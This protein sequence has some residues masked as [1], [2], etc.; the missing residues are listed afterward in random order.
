MAT[1]YTYHGYTIM[2]D[3]AE[4]DRGWWIMSGCRH[5]ADDFTSEKAARDEIDHLSM[6]D[7]LRNG[8]IPADTPSLPAPWWE[9]R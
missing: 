2:H 5:V 4:P 3:E 7:A 1:G 6:E 8:M 9:A